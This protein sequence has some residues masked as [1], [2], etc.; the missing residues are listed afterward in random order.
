V[1]RFSATN[2]TKAKELASSRRLHI[3]DA[4]SEVAYQ[5]SVMMRGL[6]RKELS[7]GRSV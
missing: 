1:A 3:M 2:Y 5:D 6:M 4:L 7:G